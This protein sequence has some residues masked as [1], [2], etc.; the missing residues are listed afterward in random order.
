MQGHTARFVS[1]L[2][3]MRNMELVSWVRTVMTIV[4]GCVV[5]IWG[6]SGAVGFGAYVLVHLLVSLALLVR[7]GNP[8][9]FFPETTPFYFTIGGVG[10]NVL[11]YVVFW[12][13]CYAGLYNF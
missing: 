7:M 4:A 10:E 1:P 12:A 9:D 11:L 2:T 8:A 13:L 3:L 5:G 6:L